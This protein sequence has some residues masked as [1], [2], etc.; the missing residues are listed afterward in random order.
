[1][2]TAPLLSMFVIPA[3]YY[4]LRRRSLSAPGSAHDALTAGEAARILVPR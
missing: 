1:M 4:L 2:I 3:A